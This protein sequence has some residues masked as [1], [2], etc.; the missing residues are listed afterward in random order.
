MI[1]GE[2]IRES[3]V[4]DGTQE[5]EENDG[6][7]IEENDNAKF[8]WDASTDLYFHASSGFY[9]NSNAGWY[10]SS[11]EG[12]YY[13]F[14]NGR[15]MPLEMAEIFQ[16]FDSL[17]DTGISKV[18]TE[19]Y[20]I[21]DSVNTEPLFGGYNENSIG[22]GDSEALNSSVSAVENTYPLWYYDHDLSE[23]WYFDKESKTYYKYDPVLG[24]GKVPK[25]KHGG[26]DGE[27]IF[28]TP[29]SIFLV[30]SEPKD[31]GITN[32]PY[33]N[34]N[35]KQ[36]SIESQSY[37]SILKG[38]P[39]GL[40]V[41]NAAEGSTENLREELLA[42]G[43]DPQ[44]PSE[45]MEEFLI[46]LYLR[47]YSKLENDVQEPPGIANNNDA[48]ITRTNDKNSMEMPSDFPCNILPFSESNIEAS[49]D[50]A[51]NLSNEQFSVSFQESSSQPNT[52]CGREWDKEI[53]EGEWVPED[54]LD[55]P[56]SSKRNKNRESDCLYSVQSE[57]CGA[58]TGNCV[59]ET[60]HLN[61]QYECSS[62]EEG[63][64][65]DEENWRAQYG[66]VVRSREQDNI[67]LSA[68]DLWE[69]SLILE[70]M[71]GKKGESARL[72]GRIA[73]RNKILHPSIQGG[74]SLLKT[75]AICEVH[76]D[77]VRVSSGQIYRLRCPSAKYVASL[78][79]FNSSDPTQGWDFPQLQLTDSAKSSEDLMD[80]SHSANASNFCED[81]TLSKPFAP[82]L[83]H[84]DCPTIKRQKDSRTCMRIKA[85]TNKELTDVELRKQRYK[86]RA[87]ERRILHGGI[88]IGPGQKNTL[89]NDLDLEQCPT[90]EIIESAGEEMPHHAFGEASLAR[91]MLEG[92]GWKE[93]ESLGN[94]KDGLISPLKAVGNKGLFGLGWTS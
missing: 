68:L 69:W 81:F 79:T 82:N 78:R 26:E 90:T 11:R 17:N 24:F 91:R 52:T 61:S 73:P 85:Y 94:R 43:G 12:V 49:L 42:E 63:N 33:D 70:C 58:S 5:G 75:A 86:D 10:Y 7:T 83:V 45:W 47:G 16:D 14:E 3:S 28:M 41:E 36:S 57:S 18:V 88:G 80:D 27:N 19:D 15:Y 92:M 44:H 65:R 1:E 30:N 89:K 67:S 32:L 35:E 59:R 31:T 50:F 29:N 76:L 72:I 21:N 38:E 54:A 93:G 56:P 87:A 2:E 74:G 62:D 66:Q 22:E 71:K 60:D 48:N 53:E 34:A 20:A 13:K 64:L 55:R 84:R 25:G 6:S 4:D 8:V 46:N 51:S 23:Y 39:T 77:L 40:T 9:H 37:A